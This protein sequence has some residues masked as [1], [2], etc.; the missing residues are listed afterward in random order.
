MP[1]NHLAFFNSP[2]LKLAPQ[3]AAM[4]RPQR[5]VRRCRDPLSRP[6]ASGAFVIGLKKAGPDP[7]A[8]SLLWGRGGRFA[9]RA[10]RQ[11]TLRPRGGHLRVAGLP[12]PC[13][14][15]ATVR[16]DPWPCSTGIQWWSDNVVSAQRLAG[17][18]D[19]GD[20]E[21]LWEATEPWNRGNEETQH[22]SAVIDRTCRDRHPRRN[23]PGTSV[24]STRN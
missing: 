13:A 19:R 4:R 6:L 21:W 17:R 20:D 3:P 23:S 9:H 14:G 11:V 16:V 2:T 10:L 24:R 5:Q 1:E 22:R 15:T 8:G 7:Q 12:L 18:A